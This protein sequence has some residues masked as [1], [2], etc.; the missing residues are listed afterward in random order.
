MGDQ[1]G[2][3]LVA[4]GMDSCTG[5]TP[6]DVLAQLLLDSLISLVPCQWLS[7]QGTQLPVC[8]TRSTLLCNLMEND[9]GSY[10]SIFLLLRRQHK[11]K[12]NINAQ[13]VLSRGLL[14]K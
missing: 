9:D 2:R 3:T 1:L 6:D 7:S 12:E 8:S 13:I 10:E 14:T 5:S 11:D 4:T